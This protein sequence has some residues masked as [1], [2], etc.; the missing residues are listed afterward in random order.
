MS[1]K[2]VFLD[3]K[4]DIVPEEEATWKVVHEYNEKGEL[5]DEIWILLKKDAEK[6]LT[7][8]EGHKPAYSRTE[9]DE[10]D[11]ET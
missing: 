2:I 5:I 6:Q 10:E 3:K 7:G 1:K 8:T 4:R 9:E 11:E